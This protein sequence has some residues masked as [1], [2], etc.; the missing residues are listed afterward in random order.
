MVVD[1][2]K[3]ALVFEERRVAVGDGVCNVMPDRRGHIVILLPVPQVYISGDLLK[4][5]P[6]R[7]AHTAQILD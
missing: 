4:P 5:E 7:D 6:P 2:G 3:V 1:Y